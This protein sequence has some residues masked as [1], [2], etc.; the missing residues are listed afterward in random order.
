MNKEVKRLIRRCERAGLAV[1]R[2]GGGHW[3]GC[4]RDPRPPP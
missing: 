3:K 1:E 4:Y 2:S